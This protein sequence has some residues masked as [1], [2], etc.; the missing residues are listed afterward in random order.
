M[1]GPTTSRLGRV[2]LQRLALDLGLSTATV[3]LAL[4]DSP[5]VAE[6]TRLRVQEAARASGYVPNRSA[7]ALRTAR[8][9]TIAVGLH[10]I[11]NPAFTE[12]LAALDDALSAAGK[13]ILL[14]VS[15]E[16]VARQTRVLGTLA[17]YRPD[18]FIV[19][20]AAHTRVEDLKALAAT[21]IPVVQVTRELEGSGLDFAGS[22]DTLGQMRA[23]AH[24]VELGH[25]RIAMIGGHEGMSTGRKRLAGYRSGLEAAGL[26]LDP[27]L[28]ISG[29][30]LREVGRAA[31]ARLLALDDPPTAAVC[32]SDLSAFGAL[33]GLQ[34]AGLTAGTDFSLVGFGDIAEAAL[35]HPAL[36][37]V[38]TRIPEYGRSAA[39]LALARI[40]EPERTVERVE[41][42][43]RLVVRATT[44]PPP[45]TRRGSP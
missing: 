40:A 43:P 30:G 25:R 15:Q 7:A 33:M 22:D 16:D 6:G 38:Y 17:E 42:E 31:V 1:E 13:T 35:W 29:P 27:A 39:R 10:E 14:G 5:V 18:A 20:P 19:S 24:L 12:L 37:T 26:A 34:A 28:V 36:T 3:S 9:N 45:S 2:T 23:V 41:L 4:R 21:G 32:F 11:L 8:T 44:G